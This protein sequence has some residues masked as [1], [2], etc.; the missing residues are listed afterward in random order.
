M[1][2]QHFNGLTPAEHE[3]L[4]MLIEEA[5]EIVQAGTKI[6]RHG[7]GSC[8]PDR[9]HTDNREELEREIVELKAIV[10]R[11]VIKGDLRNY[12]LSA[13]RYAGIMRRK[14]KYMHHLED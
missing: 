10:D 3:R 14:E 7:Y 11:M 1:T 4:S 12:N 6:L 9:P 5:A 8:H 13:D 2:D